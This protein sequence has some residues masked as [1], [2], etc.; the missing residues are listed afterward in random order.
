MVAERAQGA[1]ISVGPLQKVISG[2]GDKVCSA[3]GG[4]SRVQPHG[5]H[6]PLGPVGGEGERYAV[7]SHAI[8]SGLLPLPPGPRPTHHRSGRGI[9]LCLPWPRWVRS[10][11]SSPA[12]CLAPSRGSRC[13][14]GPNRFGPAPATVGARTHSAIQASSQGPWRAPQLLV[15]LGHGFAFHDVPE[16]TSSLA[17]LRI[18]GTPCLG[19]GEHSGPPWTRRGLLS[20]LRASPPPCF[21]APA[22]TGPG[23]GQG[24]IT[25]S[26]PR[27]RE[28]RGTVKASGRGPVAQNGHRNSS[29]L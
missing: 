15:P 20:V 9:H 27:D 26:G 18:R 3:P 13:R 11:S 2:G 5:P 4:R 25:P 24:L 23:T 21:S 29:S 28:S 16:P 8:V 14:P 10:V 1:T 12:R 6:R 17:S 22:P 19:R 7:I